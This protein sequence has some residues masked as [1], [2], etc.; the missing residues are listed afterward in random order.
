MSSIHIKINLWIPNVSKIDGHNCD[1][2]VIIKYHTI[3]KITSLATKESL[4]FENKK[5]S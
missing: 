4:D 1:R 5:K 2:I 3:N